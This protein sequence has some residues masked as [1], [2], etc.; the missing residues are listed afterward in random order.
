MVDADPQVGINI[1]M[2]ILRNILSHGNNLQINVM[3]LVA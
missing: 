3:A 1:S 2:L